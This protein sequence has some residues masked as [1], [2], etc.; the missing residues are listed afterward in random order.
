[1][2]QLFVPL[3]GAF[4][5]VAGSGVNTYGESLE[6]PHW[7]GAEIGLCDTFPD[8]LGAV[9]EAEYYEWVIGAHH[10]TH[11]EGGPAWCRF[12]DPDPAVRTEALEVACSAAQAAHRLGARYILFHFPWPALQMPG[13][14]YAALGWRF[15]DAD[16]IPMEAWPREA[17]LYDWSR[18]CFD[19]LAELQERERIRVV[20]EIDGPNPH[21]FDGELYGRLFEEFPDL[22]LCLDT[23][24]LGLLA[25]THGQ[26][27]LALAARWLPW[28]RYL[29][30]H[31]SFWD[32]QGRFHNH[33]PTRGS[34]TRDLWPRVTPAADI[35]RMVV[36]A[37]PRA[38]IVLE[39]NPQ[40]VTPQE[41]EACHEWAATLAGRSPAR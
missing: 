22:S 34:H 30:L 39:H 3:H 20:L 13:A 37:Q 2:A 5:R 19:R 33:V 27:P 31:T 21:F 36:E 4:G 24:R 41:L 1:M 28:T 10:P 16:P 14:D 23:G 32:E 6:R 15:R 18:R 12:L 38:V 9:A 40:T 17:D 35:A 25:R 11:R 29:H 8:V 26:D 7:E